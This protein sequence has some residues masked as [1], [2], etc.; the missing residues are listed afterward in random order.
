[1]TEDSRFKMPSTSA[2]IKFS[3]TPNRAAVFVDGQYVG[4]A[5]EFGGHGRGL[6]VAPGHRKINVSLSG[7]Q[8]F[9]TE[10]DLAA[11]QKFEIKTDLQ[12]EGSTQA[13]PQ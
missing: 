8:N 2:E 3:V 10:V 1:M 9:N 5:G 12:K 4:H 11:N 13:A 7:Y 6:L